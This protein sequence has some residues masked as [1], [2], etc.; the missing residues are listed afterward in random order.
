MYL[1]GERIDLVPITEND[2]ELSMQWLNDLEV[3]KYMQKPY[4]QTH[5]SMCAYLDAMKE[6]NLWLKIFV[7]TV[8]HIGNIS[9]R[10]NSANKYYS[11]ISVMIGDK[12]SWCC[13][14]ATEAIELLT[15]YCFRVRNIHKLRAGAVV[16]NIGCIKA[17]TKA[18]YTKETIE[19]EAVF[20]QGK[21]RDIVIMTYLKKDWEVKND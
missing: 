7:E 6:P 14:Y 18:G 5:K 21:F 4:F 19:K 1:I 16:D 10:D 17:F 20:A 9:L 3:T 15:D 12:D 8:K 2:F 13:G 11:E